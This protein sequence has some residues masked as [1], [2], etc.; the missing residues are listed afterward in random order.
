M[1]NAFD[2]Y[3]FVKM[4]EGTED[5]P[6]NAGQYRHAVVEGWYALSLAE[7][8]VIPDSLTAEWV[9][10]ETAKANEESAPFDEVDVGHISPFVDPWAA[11]HAL[12]MALRVI[13]NKG[14]IQEERDEALKAIGW[15]LR[16][17]EDP[18]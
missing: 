14:G 4:P 6:D 16:S 10:E 11:V 18:D 9:A 8:S 13:V 3:D 17:V 5:D 12:R 2:N 1:T 7:P 15:A